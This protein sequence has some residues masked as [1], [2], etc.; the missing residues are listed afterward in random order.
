MVTVIDCL[1]LVGWTILY[2]SLIDTIPDA[3]SSI[4]ALSTLVLS[5]FT[6]MDPSW[7]E[8][9]LSSGVGYYLN[10]TFRLTTELIRYP[11]KRSTAL[12][13]VHHT[14][15]LAIMTN[16]FMNMDRTDASR[17]WFSLVQI[18]MNI[19][20]VCLAWMKMSYK[21]NVYRHWYPPLGTTTLMYM[22]VSTFILFRIVIG[23][24]IVVICSLY[25]SPPLTQKL[26]LSTVGFNLYWL[27]EIGHKVSSLGN[28]RPQ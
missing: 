22:F 24:P 1:P 3:L 15:I 23:I 2:W 19:S 6:S 4:S 28:K 10:D 20:S 21:P 11:F 26:L 14:M 5:I 27:Y 7:A 13:V 12:F 18:T 17:Y 9:A 25:Y 16:I 8:F